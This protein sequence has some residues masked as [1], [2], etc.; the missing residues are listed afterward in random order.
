MD[1]VP[2]IPD[3]ETRNAV[4]RWII[5]HVISADDWAIGIYKASTGQYTETR[6]PA[7]SEARPVRPNTG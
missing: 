3:Q 1:S 7:L 4:T 6:S 5:A 2:Q